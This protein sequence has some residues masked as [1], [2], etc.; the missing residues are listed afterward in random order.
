MIQ[1]DFL[2]LLWKKYRWYTPSTSSC[3]A[4]T[5]HLLWGLVLKHNT[6]ILFPDTATNAGQQE[7]MHLEMRAV[8]IHLLHEDALFV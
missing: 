5:S 7:K 1:M 2:L 8:Y 3:F 4:V 6:A